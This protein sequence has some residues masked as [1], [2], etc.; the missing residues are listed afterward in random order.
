MSHAVV[1]GIAGGPRIV[2]SGISVR[3]YFAIAQYVRAAQDVSHPSCPQKEPFELNTFLLI[4]LAFVESVRYDGMAFG[5]GCVGGYSKE[6]AM[7]GKFSYLKFKDIDLSDPFFDS[8]KG[9]YPDFDRW[10]ESNSF[11]YY[12]LCC[13]Y[14]DRSYQRSWESIYDRR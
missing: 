8:L 13:G 5:S 2:S 4:K 7:A 3:R 6:V 11:V 9:D 1:G 14:R 12:V 10:F